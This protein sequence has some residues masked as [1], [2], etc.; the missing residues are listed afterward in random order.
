MYP[1]PPPVRHATRASRLKQA[2]Q[3]HTAGV[4]PFLQRRWSLR[5]RN[6]RTEKIDENGRTGRKPA[7][8]QPHNA[9]QIFIT[10]IRQLGRSLLGF[11]ETGLDRSARV[12]VDLSLEGVID[13][14]GEVAE[15][16]DGLALGASPASCRSASSQ[17]CSALPSGQPRA[18][19]RRYASSPIDR[20]SGCIA[21]LR[22]AYSPRSTDSIQV[23]APNRAGIGLSV[24]NLSRQIPTERPRLRD[25]VVEKA[26]N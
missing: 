19:Q 15:V 10:T 23:R 20:W 6:V 4:L 11:G 26:L 22:K 14:T 5:L 1:Q 13:E 25:A 3:N 9:S 8:H 21:A 2:R 16:G 18:C 17:S 7:R 24:S 12:R